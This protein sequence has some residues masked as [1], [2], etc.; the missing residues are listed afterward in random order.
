MT[1][2]PGRPFH[3]TPATSRWCSTSRAY[4]LSIGPD[5]RHAGERHAGAGG[6]D[7]A[8]DR[9]A[10]LFVGVGGGQD[11]DVPAGTVGAG[12]GTGTVAPI[13]LGEGAR[14]GVDRRHIRALDEDVENGAAADGGQE[15]GG[16]AGFG[17]REEGDGALEQSEPAV[18]PIDR[19]P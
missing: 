4:G 10:D 16:E 15:V 12:G 7:D 18:D 8:P 1:S 2:V 3:G 17:A 9:V 19:Q 13:R 6:V 14:L 5:D 11:L